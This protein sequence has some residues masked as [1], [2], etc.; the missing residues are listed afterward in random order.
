MTY[1]KRITY[2]NQIKLT[3]LVLLQ[4]RDGGSTF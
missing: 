4:E 2:H 3:K 1:K